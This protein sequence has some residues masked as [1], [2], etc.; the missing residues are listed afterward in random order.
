LVVNTCRDAAER[1]RRRRCEPLRED[2]RATR[3][4]DPERAAALSELRSE[5]GA[6]LA[7][8]P[9]SQA[10]VVVLKDAF[11]LSFEEISTAAAMP[12][13]TA[14]SYAARARTR[15]RSRLET[16]ERSVA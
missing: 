11:E 1:Q 15:L 6:G 5:L 10:R 3:D 14:K 9:P 8:L 7:G 4:G 2:L 13:G 12:V 16:L